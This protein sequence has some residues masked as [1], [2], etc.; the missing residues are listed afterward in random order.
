MIIHGKFEDALVILRSKYES[1]HPDS[2]KLEGKRVSIE[3]LEI[4]STRSVLQNRYYWGV[5]L[6]YFSD[7][8]GY[9]AEECHELMKLR[10]LKQVPL[11]FNGIAYNIAGSTKKLNTK[12]FVDYL[13][14]V[15]DFASQELN[16]YIP[17]PGEYI[18]E[19]E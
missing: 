19:E 3:I 17:S 5:V 13:N 6:K 8:T 10:F 9:S 15:R 7:E 14:N 1:K 12:E 4:K 16:C 18:G 2:V 11:I